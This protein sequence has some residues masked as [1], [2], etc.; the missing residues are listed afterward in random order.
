MT[1]FSILPSRRVATTRIATFAHLLLVASIFPSLGPL[2]ACAQAIDEPVPAAAQK[3]IDFAH[4]IVPI[5]KARCAECHT[6]G[7]YKGSFSLDTREAMLKSAAVVAGNSAD[8]ELV[9]R[10]TSHDNPEF[11]MPP[12]GDRLTAKEIKLIKNW[13]DQ[14]LPWQAGFTFKTSDYVPPLKPRRPELP[15]ARQR[16]DHPIDRIIDEYFDEHRVPMPPPLDDTAFIRRLYLDCIGL[17]PTPDELDAFLN[18]SEPNKRA[19]LIRRVLDDKRAYAEHWLTFWNDML[20][21]DYKGTGYIDG[22]RKQIT[23]WL[24]QSLVENKPYDQFV[25]ELISPSPESEGFIGGIRWRGRVNASQVRDIQFSQNVSQVFFGINMKCASCH[26]S[27]IDRWKLDDAYGLAAVIADEPLEIHRCDKPTGNQATPRFLWPELGEIDSAAPKEK[28]LEQMAALVTHPDNGRFA[29]TIANRIW[30]RLMGR[31]IV[32][33]VDVMAN[34]PWNDDLLDYLGIYLADHGYD[35]KQLIEHITTSRAYQSRHVVLA[36]E[37]SIDAYVFQGPVLKR[38]TAEQFLDAIWMITRTGPAKAV[39]PITPPE[40]SP[41]TPSDRQFIRAALVDSDLLQ[42]SLGRPNREQVV[43]TR[44][45]MLTTLQ[46]LDLANGQLLSDTL[47]RGA[48]N[49]FQANP[50]VT[51]DFLVETIYV[52][53]LCRRP[54]AEESDTAREIVGSPA[55]AESLADL[56][57]AVFMLPEFQLIR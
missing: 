33:P 49:L 20:R 7:K 53:A 25:R 56:L 37:P 47:A 15:P 45:D 1:S 26:D 51:S 36:E 54:T 14:K 44:P 27:F 9:D 46:A 34:R 12:K 32:H 41:T 30:Q 31:G 48:A 13:I 35:L 39:A 16:R 50:Q 5:I 57:W 29:R 11:R 6:N 21:N 3:P 38:M 55:T 8:S 23:A 10:I 28:R 17:L 18:D 19:Q 24:Y 4:D 22:G 42:R 2:A 43:T 52:R 40:G